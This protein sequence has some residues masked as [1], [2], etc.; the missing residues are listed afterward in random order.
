[1]SALLVDDL[2]VQLS[3]RQQAAG[4]R[5]VEPAR[6]ARLH[7]TGV[8]AAQAG[9]WAKA[10]PVR[11]RV[12]GQS[13]QLRLTDRGIAV[14]VGFFLALLATAAVVLVVSFLG[15]SNEP[16]PSGGQVLALVATQR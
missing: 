9:R 16:I 8:P 5:H 1:M 2:Y 10:A 7:P 4:W 13:A 15:V 14:I 6:Q 11:T 3:A 12:A